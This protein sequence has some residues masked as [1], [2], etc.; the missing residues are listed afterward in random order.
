MF[1]QNL[2]KTGLTSSQYLDKI[3][4]FSEEHFLVFHNPPKL[5]DTLTNQLWNL[6]VQTKYLCNKMINTRADYLLL[7]QDKTEDLI[8]KSI[9]YSNNPFRFVSYP[10]RSLIKKVISVN[11][12]VI[13][14]VNSPSFK[15][16]EK[17]VRKNGNVYSYFSKEKFSEE[18]V[19]KLQ[20]MAR[21][22]NPNINVDIRTVSG[23]II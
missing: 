6:V 2:Y 7:V 16:C 19:K 23:Y 22:T 13:I 18:Q 9:K 21:K 12:R 4:T 1:S 11:P 17:A 20:K 14:Y 8:L 15:M 10:T 3:N 5:R